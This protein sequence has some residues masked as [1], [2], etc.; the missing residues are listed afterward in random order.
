MTFNRK[1][2]DEW[3]DKRRADTVTSQAGALKGLEQAAVAAKYVTGD[4]HWDRYLSMATATVEHISDGIGRMRDKL[5]D[6]MIV[7]QTDIIK[8]KLELAHLVGM[9]EMA[10]GLLRLPTDIMKLG[11]KATLQLAGIGGVASSDD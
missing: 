2:Y 4:V 1:D 7:D 8:I 11:E 9:K 5:T 10:D 6:P 3:A